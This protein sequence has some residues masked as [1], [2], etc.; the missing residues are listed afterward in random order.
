MHNADDI[1]SWFAGESGGGVDQVEDK[2]LKIVVESNFKVCWPS[3][4]TT[5]SPQRDVPTF[6]KGFDPT[7]SQ[8]KYRV[9]MVSVFCFCVF[10]DLRVHRVPPAHLFAVN[11]RKN[12]LPSPKHDRRP[13]H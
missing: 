5:C 4:A 10:A 7:T 6:S 3:T 12:P 1:L 13:H 8:S 9:L 2:P 11:F